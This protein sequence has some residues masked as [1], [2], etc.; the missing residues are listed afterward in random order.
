[1]RLVWHSNSPTTTSAYG[2]Q[3]ALFVPR[4]AALGHEVTI[5]GPYSFGGCPIEWNGITVLP[6]ARDTA[7]CDT[8][9][10]NHE[11]FKADWT[12]VLADPFGLLRV[13]QDLSRIRLAM[14]MP[15]DC[16]PMGE[17]DVAVLRESGAVPVAI[18]R[19][20]ERV[21]AAEGATPLYAPH[22][23][24]PA[25]FCP[26]DP[27]PYRDTVPG[28]GPETLVIGIVA[29]NRDKDRKGFSEQL[30]AFSRFHARH[31]DSFLA[32]HTTPVN[33]PGLNL[34]AMAA[35]LGI[36]SAVSFPDSYMYDLNMVTQ[37]QLATFYRGCDIVSMASYGEGFG[38]PLL[39]AQSC[40]IPVVATDA[41]A[42]SELCGSGWLVTGSPFWSAGHNA[43]WRRPDTD[44][45]EQAYEAA[46]QAREDG[47]M[48]ALKQSARDFALTY[49]IDRVFDQYMKPVLADL[50]ARIS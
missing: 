1:M 27:Q 26:G 44:D 11:H 46:W 48:P 38:V 6:C 32:L 25:I 20:G 12:I 42:M 34:H 24:D 37:E 29:M 40:G 5:A 7:G 18:S 10:A 36:S 31:P 35:R 14:L 43:W 21:L 9:L 28:I 2:Q 4:I 30:L 23:V 22:A 33:N 17:G 41:S 47:K 50:E 15:I 39:E 8:I 45:I 3:T 49:D 13:A 16:D 19:F